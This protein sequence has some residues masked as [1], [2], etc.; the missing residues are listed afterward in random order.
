MKDEDFKIFIGDLLDY[1]NTQEEAIKRLKEQIA[2]LVGVFEEVEKENAEVQDVKADVKAEVSRVWSWNPDKISWLRSQGVKGEFERSEDRDNPQF[3]AM[4]KDL[5][6]HNG[7]L[8]RDGY[9][10]WVY[11]NG[12]TVGRKRR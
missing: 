4:L 1:L 2:K 12:A 6:N 3:K 8:T 7:R 9:F 5:A 11:K 10:Y